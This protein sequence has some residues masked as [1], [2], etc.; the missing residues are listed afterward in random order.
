MTAER[1]PGAETFGQRIQRRRRELGLTQRHVAK[2]VNLDFTY[3]SKLENDRG[4]PP[5]EETVRNL[6]VSLQ[7][8]VEELLALAGKV[9]A[10]LRARAQR[11]P[12]FAR[13]LRR[14]PN[15]TDTELQ[16]MY[17]RS[18]PPRR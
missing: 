10:E 16:D 14:L 6:A 13:F 2:E 3:L 5:G 9:P 17:K 15:L 4:D 7:D 12:E 18:R 11:D 1:A 8:D